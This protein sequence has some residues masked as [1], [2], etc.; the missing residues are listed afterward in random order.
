MERK[1]L[2]MQR[3]I[4]GLP[5]EPYNPALIRANIDKIMT[6]L[7]QHYAFNTQ[8]GFL[9]ALNQCCPDLKLKIP[10]APEP[11]PAGAA[12]TAVTRLLEQ[13][14][15]Q[16]Q[17]LLGV[18]ILCAV[19]YHRVPVKMVEI[20]ETTL[21]P[22]TGPCWYDGSTWQVNGRRVDPP[23]GF[24][25]Y[26]RGLDSPRTH[27]VV[28]RAGQPYT[29]VTSLC[30]SFDLLFDRGFLAVRQ[31]LAQPPPTR[32]P[33][34]LRPKPLPEV[35]IPW[36]T[37]NDSAIKEVSN[38]KHLVHVQRLSAGL[39]QP[40]DAFYPGFYHAVEAPAK[41]RAFLEYK[42]PD[43]PS[44][45]ALET[46]R[47]YIGALCK[48]LSQTPNFPIHMYNVYC[49]IRD[50]LK[51]AS[52]A[53]EKPA[54]VEF[55]SLLPQLQAYVQ[56][57]KRVPGFRV[58]CAMICNNLN[59]LEDTAEEALGVLRMSDVRNTRFSADGEH[60]YIDLAGRQWH[61]M[62]G[63]T[64]N[65]KARTLDLPENFIKDLRAIYPVLPEWLL[66]NKAG[67]RYDK[68]DSL[69]HMFKETLKLKFTDIRSSYTTYRHTQP[70][71]VA[72][73]TKLSQ[74][75]GHSLRTAQADYVRP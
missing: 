41:V 39:S 20:I 5:Q 74:N 63:C 51:L 69:S 7:G 52:L 24:H 31:L 33:L 67:Q 50:E 1:I 30:K 28:N 3:D 23:V 53:R 25:T 62:A 11:P 71:T 22:A 75:M 57:K 13:T 44:G 49:K 59:L 38:A 60:S 35:G 6:Y 64:K 27:L 54:V 12:Y 16:S 56:D 36:A 15:A 14:M 9:T 29:Q 72:E 19:L 2:Q 8:R 73:L 10:P 21:N 17:Q 18:K 70:G 26:V 48:F 47:S 43:R 58:L 55:T 65:K 42:G 46:Q 4:L 45:Y 37:Y 40:V 68:M 61:I 32:Q 34:R 66:I